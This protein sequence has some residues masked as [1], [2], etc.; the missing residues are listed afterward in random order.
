M[1]KWQGFVVLFFSRLREEFYWSFGILTRPLSLFIWFSI[2][3]VA[4]ISGP[5]GTDAVMDWPMRSLYWF[6]IT[7]GGLVIGVSARAVTAAWIGY[8]RPLVFDVVATLLT[9]AILAPLVWMLRRTVD[10]L[11]GAPSVALFNV[12]L[13]SLVIV[14]L[15]F[16]VRRHI[17]PSE[18]GSYLEPETE[19]DPEARYYA[20]EGARNPRLYRRLSDMTTGTILRLSG[21]DHHVEVITT[22]AR[23]T[24]RLRLT[25]A[26]G[27]M[28]PVEGYCTHRSHWVARAAIEAVDRTQ[29]GKVFIVLVNGDRIPVSRKYR[30]DLEAAGILD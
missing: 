13:H 7:A 26:I 28:D 4:I 24:L 6:S 22:E 27:E 8:G 10:T 30:P 15:V 17:S 19:P 21:M 1:G 18:P 14:G 23:E 29:P 5:F 16:V 25:D 12:T 3:L 9:T 20:S 11:S 2:S